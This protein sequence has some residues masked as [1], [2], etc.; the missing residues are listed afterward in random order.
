[1][2]GLI[3]LRLMKLT[4]LLA[5]KDAFRALQQNFVQPVMST[6]TT[7]SRTINVKSAQKELLLILRLVKRAIRAALPV[8]QPPQTA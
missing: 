4:V 8:K 3:A 5:L 6:I 1:M 2:F 7:T